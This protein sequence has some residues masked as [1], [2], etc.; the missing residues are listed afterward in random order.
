MRKTT[1]NKILQNHR[2]KTAENFLQSLRSSTEEKKERKD[3]TQKVEFADGDDRWNRSRLRRRCHRQPSLRRKRPISQ[4]TT[5]E[6][7][8]TLN[9]VEDWTKK[10]CVLNI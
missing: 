6:A 5:K 7:R 1:H 9:Q 2:G 8:C 4:T 10:S 3:D